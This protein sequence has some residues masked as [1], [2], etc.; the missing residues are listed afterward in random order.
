MSREHGLSRSARRSHRILL[1]LLATELLGV[2]SAQAQ[3]MKKVA[4]PIDARVS[5]S[6]ALPGETVQIQGTSVALGQRNT[7]VVRVQPPAGS[8]HVI[9]AKLEAS[10]S[11][12][13]S[14]VPQ[15]I[16]KYHV[17]AVSPDGKAK[18]TTSFVAAAPVEFTQQ[19]VAAVKT[20]L[21]KVD[22]QVAALATQVGK[23]P[24]SPPQQ[25]LL[26]RLKTIRQ[27]LA[28]APAQVAN[29]QT[30][31]NDVNE[32]VKQYPDAMPEVQP[33]Y[34]AFGE[35]KEK[36]DELAKQLVR[37]AGQVTVGITDCNRLDMAGEAITFLGNALLLL[38]EPLDIALGVLGNSFAARVS[39]RVPYLAAHSDAKFAVDTLAR[40][41]KEFFQPVTSWE[42]A[43]NGYI[44]DAISFTAMEVFGV[45]CEKYEGP[46]EASLHVEYDTGRKPWLVYDIRL[47][48]IMTLRYDKNAGTPAQLSGE[49][50][51]AAQFD[52]LWDDAVLLQPNLRRFTIAHFT[53]AAPL[54]VNAH[55]AE[56]GKLTRASLAKLGVTPGYF[57]VPVEGLLQGNEMAIK[58]KAATMDYPDRV[59]GLLFYIM[60]EP[61]L[62][63]PYVTR[64]EI[65]YQG[66][67]FILSRGTHK[68]RGKS[69][70]P[71]ALQVLTDAKKKTSYV[72]KSY[73]RHEDLGD[74]KVDFMVQLKACNPGCPY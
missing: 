59:K 2:G 33:I 22:G 62:P 9:E 40:H 66:A 26:H 45:Y 67:Q 10:G 25:E 20:L 68:E 17:T 50:E 44:S 46:F 29:L 24:A 70:E 71:F 72:Q 11:F 52:K 3:E 5:R 53:R 16:G 54:G 32:I 65:P 12:H 49:F 69:S 36:G 28:Q 1:A 31:M 37:R 48:G 19:T 35:L 55:L 56:V 58:F 41:A 6:L 18:A 7:V 61:A 13:V 47:S 42:G 8:E 14:Y 51:G 15:K 64:V 39:T 63:I 23:V 43:V 27:Q 34:D 4:T 73:T 30:A 57:F 60:L 38:K 21:D 74:T